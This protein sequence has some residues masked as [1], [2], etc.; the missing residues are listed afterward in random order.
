[1]RNG[2]KVSATMASGSRAVSSFPQ[3]YRRAVVESYLDRDTG[4]K[5]VLTED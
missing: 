1:M 4:G 2:S 5:M 3:N